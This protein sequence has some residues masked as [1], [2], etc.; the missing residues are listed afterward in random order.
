MSQ[1][2]DSNQWFANEDNIVTIA[3]YSSINLVFDAQNING[4]STNLDCNITPIYHA[5]DSKDYN[6]NIYIGQILGDVNG[7]GGLNVLD[8]VMLINTILA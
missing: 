6:F 5:Y 4:D 2:N 1:I 7:D 8:V 3:P